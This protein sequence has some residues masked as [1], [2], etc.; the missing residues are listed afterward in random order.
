MSVFLAV[1]LDP[2]FPVSFIRFLWQ[3]FV[4]FYVFA[5]RSSMGATGEPQVNVISK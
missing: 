1:Q 3:R 5:V 4:N 2:F